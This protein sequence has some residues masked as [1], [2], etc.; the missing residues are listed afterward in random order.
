MSQVPPVH[1]IGVVIL[2]V[3]DQNRVLLGLRAK[4][5][6][7]ASFGGKLDPGELVEAGAIREVFEETGLQLTGL[8]KLTF[9]EGVT[10]SGVPYVTLY[11]AARLPAGQQPVLLEPKAITQMGWFAVEALPTAMWPL[12]REVIKALLRRA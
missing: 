1:L 12:E 6:L 10:P 5:Q 9:G 11:F 2:V 7:W 4:E 3:D 8:E